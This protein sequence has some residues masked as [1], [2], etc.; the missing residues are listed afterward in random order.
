MSIRCV[1]R[2]LSTWGYAVSSMRQLLLLESWAE[3]AE[4][5]EVF[6]VKHGLTECTCAWIHAVG[7]PATSDCFSQSSPL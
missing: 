6:C 5:A 7:A 3:L 2:G 1:H 4:A